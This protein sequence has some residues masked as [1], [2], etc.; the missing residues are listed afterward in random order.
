MHLI[1]LLFFNSFIQAR[2][3]NPLKSLFLV[4]TYQSYLG[5]ILKLI[6]IMLQLILN[7]IQVVRATLKQFG[8]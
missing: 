3:L 1:C 7:E 8:S 2:Y 4:H 6:A 5:F